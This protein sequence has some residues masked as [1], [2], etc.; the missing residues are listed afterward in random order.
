MNFS[1]KIPVFYYKDKYEYNNQTFEWVAINSIRARRSKGHKI[2]VWVA[3]NSNEHVDPNIIKTRVK[4]T[5]RISLNVLHLI[6]IILS[7]KD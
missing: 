2:K 6:S 7:S 4:A 1:Y 3:V 5:P